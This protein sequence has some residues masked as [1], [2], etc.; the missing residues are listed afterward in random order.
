MERDGTQV[1]TSLRV[2]I[3]DSQGGDM[4]NFEPHLWW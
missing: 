2:T 4:V 1:L 3:D